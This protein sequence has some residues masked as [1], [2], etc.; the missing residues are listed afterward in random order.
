[1]GKLKIDKLGDLLSGLVLKGLRLL[2]AARARG[3]LKT[4]TKPRLRLGGGGSPE[5][6]GGY[7]KKHAFLNTGTLEVT[8]PRFSRS[9][10]NTLPTMELSFM[11]GAD[12]VL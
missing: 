10:E 6:L 11:D 12:G 9:S 8:D 4:F 2:S 3:S 7:P 5:Q 1:M